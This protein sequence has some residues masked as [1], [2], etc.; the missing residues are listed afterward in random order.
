MGI[1]F[2]TAVAIVVLI[3]TGAWVA[4]GEFSFVGSGIGKDGHSAAAEPSA[5]ED[6]EETA[7]EPAEVLQAVAFVTAMPSAYERWIRLSGQTEAD[8]QVM[9]VARASGTVAKLPVQ[10]GD[11]VGQGDLVMALDAPEKYVAVESA[12]ALFDSAAHEAESNQQLKSRGN[13]PELKLEV[14]IAAREA[15]RSALEAARAEVDRLEVHAPFGGVVNKVLVELGSWVQPGT[16]VASLLALDPIVVVGEINERDLP[17]V[18][19]GTRAKVTFGD[20]TVGEGE[21]RYVQH[22]SSGPTRT[23]PIEV[24]IANPNADIAAGLSAEIELAAE[25]T[26]A[27]IL[28]RSTLT[29][30]AAGALGVRVLTAEDTVGFQKVTIVDDTPRGLVL[31]GVHEGTRIIVSGQDMVSDG[32]QVTAVE[33][34][35]QLARRETAE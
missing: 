5:P 1:R 11:A 2:H 15:A 23:F 10:D 29:L 31:S 14:S 6:S 30:D 19:E 27:V 7:V 9:L 13:L 16:E 22:E 35:G 34:E 17:S 33:A 18:S 25:P 4:T 8:K 28:P 20:G 32:Q 12:K 24:A 26:P 21:V 3:V